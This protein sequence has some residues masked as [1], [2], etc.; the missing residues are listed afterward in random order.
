M[1]CA[2]C[3]EKFSSFPSVEL[4]FGSNVDKTC[5][6][7]HKVSIKNIRKTLVIILIGVLVVIGGPVNNDFLKLGEVF[8]WSVYGV[9]GVL[10]LL[11]FKMPWYL[12]QQGES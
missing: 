10:V 11:T 12:K 8:F 5:S 3:G 7:C 6:E 1:K 9:A 2:W 4:I